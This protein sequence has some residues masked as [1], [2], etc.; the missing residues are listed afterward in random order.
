MSE[1]SLSLHPNCYLGIFYYSLP[2][3]LLHSDSGSHIRPRN[4]FIPYLH[5]NASEVNL[6]LK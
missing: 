3:V 1:S 6:I 5:P 2:R 4:R